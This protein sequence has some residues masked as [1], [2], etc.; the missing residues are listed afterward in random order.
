VWRARPLGP[1]NAA[2]D[3]SAGGDPELAAAERGFWR[4]L[5]ILLS[6]LVIMFVPQL[7]AEPTG[8]LANTRQVYRVLWPQGW[9][10]FAESG[11]AEVLVVY[12]LPADGTTAPVRLTEPLMA[13][14][15]LWGV[16]RRSYARQ[17]EAKQIATAMPNPWWQ[18]CDGSVPACA[19]RLAGT[20]RRSVTNRAAQP[21]LCGALLIVLQRPAAPGPP[22]TRERRTAT[23]ARAVALDV[24]CRR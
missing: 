16:R 22:E 13:E 12:R 19:L 10:F 11:H 23:A 3:A 9:K 8:W 20:P 15:N 24:A 21:R 18:R 14:G 7:P 6:A 5:A 1:E 2:E 4:T 17:V